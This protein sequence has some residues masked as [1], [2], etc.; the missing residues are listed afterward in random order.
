MQIIWI[1][2]SISAEAGKLNI[3]GGCNLKNYSNAFYNSIYSSNIK[4]KMVIARK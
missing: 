2:S 1:R 4:E 3:E